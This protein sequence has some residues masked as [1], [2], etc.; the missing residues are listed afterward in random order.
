MYCSA[1]ET[2]LKNIEVI[3]TQDLD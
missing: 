3:Q 2:W 1:S